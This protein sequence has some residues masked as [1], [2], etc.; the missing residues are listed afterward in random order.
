MSFSTVLLVGKVALVTGG[1]SPYGIGRSLVL[2]LAQAGA[3]AVYATDLTLTNIPSLQKEVIDSGSSCQIHAK[4]LD[5]GSEE[6]TVAVLKE[7]L[8]EQGLY[9]ALFCNVPSNLDYLVGRTLQNTEVKDYD[10]A[11]SVMQRSFFLAL[12]YGGQA[13]ATT[14]SSKPSSGGSIIV[15]SSMAD[16]NGAVSDISYST[17]KAAVASMVKP[18]AVQLAASHIRV[19]SIAPGFV[20]TSI[21][22]TSASTFSGNAFNEK[23]DTEASKVA[24]DNT[25]EP[26]EITNIG[27]FLVSD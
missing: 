20:R 12:K 16:V 23:L 11:I 13:L 15:T 10:F 2:A 8:S 27:V 4:R 17:A 19:N 22:A 7:I 9:P 21:V 5:V 18:G 14:S 1:G 6:Q 26:I 3:K 24:F 25:I